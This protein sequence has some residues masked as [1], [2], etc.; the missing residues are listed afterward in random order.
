MVGLALI[1]LQLLFRGWFAFNNWF[2]FDD[3]VFLT[4][5]NDAP[6]TTNLLLEGYGGHFMPAGFLLTWVFGHDGSLDYTPYAVTLVAMQALASVGFLVLL[7][8]LFGSRWAVLVPLT[9]YLFLGLSFPAYIWWA[10]GVNQIAL[11]IALGWGLW[12]HLNYLR[13]RRLRWAI[14]TALMLIACL[15]FYE[16]VLLVYGAIAIITLAY[17][18]TGS[19]VQRVVHVWRTYRSAT[20][21]HVLSGVVY[22]AAYVHFAYNFGGSDSKLPHLE[23]VW[24]LLGKALLP[25]VIGGPVDWRVLTG[26]FQ[27]ADPPGLFVVAGWCAVIA[28]VLHVSTVTD[29]SLR[30]WLLVA[31]FLVCGVVLLGSARASVVGPTAG[32]EFRY[33]TEFA[34]VVPLALA[35]AL[36][37][38]VGAA[39][40][41]EPRHATTSPFLSRAPAVVGAVVVVSTLGLVSSWQYGSHWVEADAPR[42]YFTNAEKTLGTVEEPT[43]L[44]NVS[45]PDYIMWGYEYP[46]N[47]TKYVLHSYR[48]RMSFPLATQDQLFVLNDR[49]TVRPVAISPMHMSEPSPTKCGFVGV[50]GRSAQIQLSSMVDTKDL[51]TRMSYSAEEATPVTVTA[52]DSSYDVN[53]EQGL[54]NMY[55]HV[56]GAFSS[57]TV[58]VPATARSRVCLYDAEV[59]LPVATEPTGEQ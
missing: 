30:A 52:G 38:V 12:A 47:T 13:T 50:P 34:M 51:W 25:G 57:I 22:L 26:A 37:P 55:F 42:D 27:L 4:R 14:A 39:E 56:Q 40:S 7:R 10:A 28:L 41:A 19:S 24:N 17:F 48:Q 32:L 8:S 35:L 46:L 43:P 59:G 31:W 45:V 6:L 21:I 9:L 1:G 36:L 2:Q 16:K 33:L 18:A 11:Q 53:L 15:A 49:G 5:V 20:V 54:H 44:V 3:L 29:R 23:L 58:D